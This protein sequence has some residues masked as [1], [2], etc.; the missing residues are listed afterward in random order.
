MSQ[1]PIAVGETLAGKYRIERV[2]GEGGMG[3]VVAAHHLELEQPVAI[4]FLLDKVADQEG[5]ER[6]RREARAAAKI[7]SDHVVRVLDVGVL[8]EEGVRYMVM[9][10]LEG[11][12]LAEELAQRGSLPVGVACGYLLEAIDAIGQAH[13][14]GI[15]HRDLKPANLFLTRRPDGSTRVKVLDFGISKS[16]G[17]SSSQELSL[18]KTSAW[19]GSPLYMAP[20]QMQS[21]RD[22]DARAD[23][24]SLGA[25]LYEMIAGVPPYEAET[26][27]Q[28]CS[29]LITQDAPHIAA[30]CPT[31]AQDLADLV[32]GCLVRDREA[33]IPRTADLVPLL[34][35]Y[36][37]TSAG[38][39][40]SR[41]LL[42]RT[43]LQGTQSM[44]AA[45]LAGSVAPNSG[46]AGHS[47]APVDSGRSAPFAS[48]ADGARTHA[49]WGAAGPESPKTG[50]RRIQLLAFAVL[51]ASAL[52]A[53]LLFWGGGAGTRP[54]AE[55]LAVDEQ[56]AALAVDTKPAA[57]PDM[58]EGRLP[59]PEP[60][61]HGGAGLLPAKEP[62]NSGES[63]AEPAGS[64]K[65]DAS[66]LEVNAI[67]S[68]PARQPA[69]RPLP[70]PVS[71]P[72]PKPAASEDSAA[73]GENIE[74]LFGG[75]R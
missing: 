73:G 61:P 16:V 58:G 17:P 13:A 65:P 37:A 21:A 51:A 33:R 6:F 49:A 9:E 41:S 4:K 39:S 48:L 34:R 74:D 31:L 59:E 8:N 12:D 44:P 43:E 20:E 32:M 71:R 40:S 30:R 11:Q 14:V 2:I 1:L 75:R 62:K 42:E 29:L 18:T 63:A 70:R 38:S 52:G 68:A 27:P 57:V 55:E 15:V 53:A 10:Y 60:G 67:Q 47:L 50:S 3:I 72:T 66:P 54:T 7:H 26:L 36:A 19:I 46:V 24:W 35:H 69:V 64:E 22:V 56:N 28:L 23:I 25:I 45:R 5:A